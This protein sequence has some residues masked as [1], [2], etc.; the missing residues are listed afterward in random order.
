MPFPSPGV[1]PDPGTE[2]TSPAWQADSLPL[3]H[4]GS[5]LLKIKV[6]LFFFN[7]RIERKKRFLTVKVIFH[8]ESTVCRS[9]FRVSYM[10]VFLGAR[11]TQD[12]M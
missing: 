12:T 5:P 6:F 2:T 4:S 7:P 10:T 8:L 9:E 1:L 11:R 3:S